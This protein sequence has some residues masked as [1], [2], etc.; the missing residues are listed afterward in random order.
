M[1][2]CMVFSV[3]DFW[4]NI[5]G[6]IIRNIF[7]SYAESSPGKRWHW[8]VVS[9]QCRLLYYLHHTRREVVCREVPSNRSHRQ[10]D[11]GNLPTW[12]DP[13]YRGAI[14]VRCV[15]RILKALI[16]YGPTPT[17]LSSLL[18]V[19]TVKCVLKPRPLSRIIDVAIDV[20]T[21]FPTSRTGW[22]ESIKL[23]RSSRWGE[24]SCKL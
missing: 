9:G 17:P 15:F 2:A 16:T 24:K 20:A 10:T 1:L 12:L 21:L 6:P 8:A 11:P 14:S 4:K 5:C 7:V 13:F 18:N 23:S 3:K 19:P 22:G